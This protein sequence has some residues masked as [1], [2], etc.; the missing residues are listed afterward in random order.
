MKK[1]FMMLIAATALLFSACGGGTEKKAEEAQD[2]ATK[3]EEVVEQTPEVST[4]E[5][6]DVLAQYEALVDQAV[7]LLQ[8]IQKGDVSAATEYQELNKKISDLLPKLQEE[9]A[10]MTPE[11]A[12]KYQELAK[13]LMDAATPQ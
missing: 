11:K 4:S 3:T 12:A 8:K 6:G 7:P 5:S 13:K 10:N 2:E 9:A 1:T